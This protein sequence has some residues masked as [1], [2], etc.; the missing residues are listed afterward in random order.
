M[1]PQLAKWGNYARRTA[2]AVL[3]NKKKNAVFTLQRC[4]MLVDIGLAPLQFYQY[5][6]DD[7][8]KVG[9]HQDN[10]RRM[11]PRH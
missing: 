4:K 1:N 10:T 3:T 2:I 9:E 5:G 6:S 11:Q 7:I 8:D